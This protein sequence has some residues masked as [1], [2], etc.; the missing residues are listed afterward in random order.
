WLRLV[1]GRVG[2]KAGVALLFL[3]PALFLFTLFV[4]LP[5]GEAAWYSFY[6]WNGFGSPTQFVGWRNFDLLFANRAFRIALTNNG[7]IIAVSL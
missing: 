7:L 1:A 2:P 5:M 6:N 4:A 3:P